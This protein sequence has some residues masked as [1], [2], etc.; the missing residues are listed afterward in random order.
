LPVLK[1]NIKLIHFYLEIWK[2]QVNNFWYTETVRFQ[3]DT[4]N[5]KEFGY[6]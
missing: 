4:I 2:N 5:I 1:K 3:V 6:V